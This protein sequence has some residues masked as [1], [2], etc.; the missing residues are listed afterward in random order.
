MR[1]ASRDPFPA[2]PALCPRALAVGL[3][4]FSCHVHHGHHGHPKLK[5]ENK[6]KGKSG[7]DNLPTNIR[8]ERYFF[9]RSAPRVAM[10]AIVAMGQKSLK[11]PC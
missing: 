6:I 8:G 2:A 9:K 7:G 10:V 3:G 1:W 11:V 5:L 4:V